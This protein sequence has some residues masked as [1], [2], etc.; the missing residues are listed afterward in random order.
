[1]ICVEMKHGNNKLMGVNPLVSRKKHR[2]TGRFSFGC[3]DCRLLISKM[4]E[5]ICVTLSHKMRLQECSGMA[6]QCRE[7]IKL[8]F[9]SSHL[10]NENHKEN[11]SYVIKIQCLWSLLRVHRRSHSKGSMRNTIAVANDNSSLG[12]DFCLQSFCDVLSPNIRLL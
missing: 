8:E 5:S 11:P 1:M 9:V 3:H 12:R 10:M 6:V 7:G 2:G 4:I